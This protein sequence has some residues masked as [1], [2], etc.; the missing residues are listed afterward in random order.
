MKHLERLQPRRALRAAILEILEE[1]LARE[2]L[3]EQHELQRFAP[4]SVR[5]L[6]CDDSTISSIAAQNANFAPYTSSAAI[7][8]FFARARSP[9][10]IPG[11]AC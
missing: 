7:F 11:S 3:A 9:T 4:H 1:L 6:N 2:L 10:G 5:I 8:S